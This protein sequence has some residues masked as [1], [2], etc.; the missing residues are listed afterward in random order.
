MLARKHMKTKTRR[1]KSKHKE[2]KH[3]FK[4]NK[5]FARWYDFLQLWS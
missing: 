1:N 5:Y 3:N 2:N 4:D